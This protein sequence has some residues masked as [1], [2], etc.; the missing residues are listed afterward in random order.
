MFA[1]PAVWYHP[2]T[3]PPTPCARKFQLQRRTLFRCFARPHATR[4]FPAHTHGAAAS[5]ARAKPRFPLFRDH[6]AHLLP[7]AAHGKTYPYLF[8]PAP[9]RLLISSS[10][11]VIHNISHLS[12]SFVAAATV[13]AR[14]GARRQLDG[15]RSKCLFVCLSVCRPLRQRVSGET[16]TKRQKKNTAHRKAHGQIFG[17]RKRTGRP[18]MPEEGRKAAR[19]VGVTHGRAVPTHFTDVDGLLIMVA[20]SPALLSVCVCVCFYARHTPKQNHS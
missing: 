6:L 15:R 12:F 2:P 1:F 11:F 3:Y 8:Q 19:S 4:T 5:C 10:A 7:F 16:K 9:H 13:F 17:K 20:F 18:W 14:F